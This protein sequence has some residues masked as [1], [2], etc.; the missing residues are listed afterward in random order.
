M[1][2]AEVPSPLGAADQQ[3]VLDH[4]P[5]Q[6]TESLASEISS[7]PTGAPGALVRSLALAAPKA[8]PCT[9][10]TMP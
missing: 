3:E 4:R 2:E 8:A 5:L 10:T 9:S 1:K 6:V 7:E